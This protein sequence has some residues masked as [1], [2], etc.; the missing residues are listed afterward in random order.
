MS[1]RNYN[2]KCEKC[3]GQ[4]T[5]ILNAEYEWCKT[6]QTKYLETFTNEN[7]K[8]VDLFQ[9]IRLKVNDPNDILF[10]WIPYDQF[11]N[12]KEIG[13]SDFV[14]VNSAIWKN[15]PLSYSYFKKELTRVSEKKVVLK[16]LHNSQN[17]INELLSEI[18]TYSINNLDNI[19][20]I[21]G[22]SQ[23]PDTKDYIMVLHNEYFGKCCKKC[24]IWKDGPLYYEYMVGWTRESDKKVAL[25]CLYNS[26]NLASDFLNEVSTYSIDYIDDNF[27]IYGISQNPN[28]KDYIMVLQQSDKEVSLKSL[29]NSKDINDEF[30][31]EAKAYLIMNSNF[32]LNIYGISQDPKTKDYIMVLESIA[33]ENLN[34]WVNHNYK[35]FN[36]PNKI[37]ILFYIIQSLKEIHQKQMIHRDFHTGNMLISTNSVDNFNIII[38]NMG[39]CGEVGNTDETKIYG[40]IRYTAPEVLSGKSY[41]QAADIYSFG[42]IMYYVVTG[43]NPRD[44]IKPEII[45]P[46]AP[47]RYIDLMEKCLDL[48]PDI[49]PNVNEIEELINL[50][51]YSYLDGESDFK[52]VIKVSTK[53]HYEIRKQFEEAEKYRKTILSLTTIDDDKGPYI[54]LIQTASIL[55]MEIIESCEA[56]EYNRNIC[57]VLAERVKITRA[58]LKSLQLRKQKNEKELRNESYYDACHKFIYVLKEIKEYTKD[59]S[60]IHCFRKYTKATFVEEKFTRLTDG[61]DNAM[62]DL[63]FTLVVANEERRKNDEEALSKDLAEFDKYLRAMGDKV[64][65]IY[66]EIKYIKKHLYDKTFHGANRI[67]SKYLELPLRGKFDDKRGK[68]P[69]YVVK[70]IY[71]GQEVACKSIS[72]TAKVQGHLEILIKLS[73]CNHILRFYGVSKIDDDNVRVFEWAHRGT[74]KELYEKKD[75]QWHYKVQ[76]SLKICRGLI[77]L[78]KAEILH[79]DLR[80]EN[81]LMTE[82]LEPKIYN[83]KLSRYAFGNTTTIKETTNDAVRWLAPEKLINYKSKYT[84]QCEIFSFGVLLW[85]L[86]F[87]K[88]PYRSLEVDKIRDFVIKGGRERIKFGDSTPKKIQEDYKKIINDIWKNNPQERISFLKALDML[89]ELYNS[90]SYMFD[91]SIPALLDENTLDLDGS[92]AND[93]FVLPDDFEPLDDFI[94]PVVPIIP[95]DEGIKAHR[96]RDYQKAWKCFEYHAEN[97]N[98]TAKCWKGRYLWEGFHDGIKSREEGKELLK[99]AADEGHHDAQLF[100]AFT[101]VRVLPENNNI[102]T[103]MK[104]ITK[105]AEG[106]NNI[107]QYNLGDIYYN[108][109]LNIPKNEDEGI[110]W[111]RKA[112]FNDNN[113]AIRFLE[114]RGIRIC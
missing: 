24:A 84:T 56:A 47:K 43:N 23:N 99:E 16:C 32:I 46:K 53:Q 42:M 65:N 37:R 5:N 18:K 20:K 29:Y 26:Q 93:E 30:L 97:G 22:I 28:T 59:I 78:Q 110:K 54:P 3:V 91:E 58:S 73:E 80:C 10:E 40:D 74:L 50:L 86:A 15:G 55:I 21:Y 12:I 13:K 27:K 111:L 7:E 101:F 76:I 51:C 87:E 103:F 104:Y 71:R 102:D 9:E 109:K 48:N 68:H 107:A 113:N 34:D 64:D 85:E 11:D 52:R 94:D 38:S 8:I 33:G 66:D 41:T 72:T 25:K 31:N 82:S 79:H 1:S 98:T 89:E 92:K 69:N 67:D 81:I 75:I 19:L 112:A 100:Y 4:Y 39:S 83:F 77:F 96:A 62:K 57:D 61:Y 44:G 45:G 2:R 108:G 14:T 6:C 49:R 114:K 90:I 88:I 70:R 17:N 36:W 105:S 35:D 60:K 95:L 63:N 106:N